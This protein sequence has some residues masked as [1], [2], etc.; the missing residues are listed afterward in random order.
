MMV[1]YQGGFSPEQGDLF[2]EQGEFS[3]GTGNAFAENLTP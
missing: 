2:P 3:T 1:F